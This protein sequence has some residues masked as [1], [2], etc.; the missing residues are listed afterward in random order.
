VTATPGKELP[1]YKCHK[2][3]WALKIAEIA[4]TADG[5]LW[6][7]PK[8]E[9]YDRFY[10]EPKFVPKHDPGRPQPGWYFVEYKNGYKS[11]SP[12]DAFEDGYTKIK[13]I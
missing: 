6:I 11:F 5:G 13:V 1:R 3:V 2:E 10:V 8:E 12:A 9:G 4:H 7:V